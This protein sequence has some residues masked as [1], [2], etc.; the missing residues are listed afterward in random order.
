M[1]RYVER[2]G[3]AYPVREDVSPTHTVN[4]QVVVLLLW[5][6]L[7]KRLGY[8]LLCIVD[9]LISSQALHKLCV[10]SGADANDMAVK[11]FLGQLHTPSANPA[12]CT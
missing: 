11:R 5:S 3:E 12:A 6:A 1:P 4:V 9:N 7:Q 10:A 2:S 8:V